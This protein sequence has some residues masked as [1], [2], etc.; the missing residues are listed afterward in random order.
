M[1]KSSELYE[2]LKQEERQILVKLDQLEADASSMSE[3]RDGSPFGKREEEADG[4]LEMERRIAQE[5]RA[6][7]S[8]ASIEHALQKY[9]AGTYGLCDACGQPIEQARLE[10]LPQASLCLKCKASQT[11]DAKGTR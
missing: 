1:A 7:V 3:R 6:R 11:K 5:E 4:A 9:E 10:A 2:R 8:L